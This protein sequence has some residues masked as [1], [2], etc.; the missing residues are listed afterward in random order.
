MRWPSARRLTSLPVVIVTSAGL[1][2]YIEHLSKSAAGIAISVALFAGLAYVS[3]RSLRHGIVLTWVAG[4]LIPEFPRDIL[5]VYEALQ[6]SSGDVRK[7][8]VLSSIT[9]GPGS[10]LVVLF[11]LNTV[12]ALRHGARIRLSAWPIVAIAILLGCGT[13]GLVGEQLGLA[14]TSLQSIVTD[15]KFPILLAM[16][17]IQGAYLRE[18]ESI[19]LLVR[20]IVVLPMFIGARAICFVVGDLM[21]GMP[22]LDLMTQPLLATA[23]V[24]YCAR[25]GSEGVFS[26]FSQRSLLY[27]SLFSASRGLMAVQGVFLGATKLLG[28]KR[29]TASGRVFGRRV[30]LELVVI[31]AGLLGIVAVANPRLFAFVL[32]KMADIDALMGDGSLSGSGQVRVYEIKN[33]VA[34]ALSSPFKLLF[35]NGFGGTFQFNAAPLPGEVVLDLK[36]YGARDLATG[37]YA[38]THSFLSFV[39]LKYGVIGLVV[40]FSLPI[41]AAVSHLRSRR[42]F[43]WLLFALALLHVYNY[44]WRIEFMILMGVLIGASAVGRTATVPAGPRLQPEAAP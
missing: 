36:S 20:A 16:G 15:V 25:T 21:Q 37:M 40:Y 8:Y 32:W 33:V 13:A 34:I 26:T 35:G 22:Q 28:R 44:Y 12:L 23:V 41:R 11:I 27:L 38:T 17:V 14:Q 43:G 19:D 2:V 29:E 9:V 30:A 10:M 3:F 6:A 39:L 42:P 1:A 4:V 7:Y 31:L 24:A 18:T 5:D